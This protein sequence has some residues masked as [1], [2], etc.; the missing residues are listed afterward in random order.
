MPGPKPNSD[1]EIV[2]F[3]G[4]RFKRYPNSPRLELRRY[5]TS[6]GG[7]R[8]HRAI[9]E[10]NYGQIPEGFHVHHKDGDTLNNAPANLECLP[11]AEHHREHEERVTPERRVRRAEH[12]ARI[13]PLTK[14]WHSSPEGLEWHRKH[15][16]V[17]WDGFEPTTRKCELCGAEYQDH[18][19]CG[20]ARFCSN[21]CKSE[22]RRRAGVDDVDRKCSE[23]GAVFRINR[24][25]RKLTCSPACASKRIS[26]ARSAR[27]RSDR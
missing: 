5:F 16:A 1:T 13:R 7:R 4:E 20:V 10:A 8:L 11:P 15:A 18:S 12:A 14:A 27:V 23:C 24:Y 19:K 25:A 21:N 6:Q 22:W 3:H 9:W 26:R 2:E 17:M